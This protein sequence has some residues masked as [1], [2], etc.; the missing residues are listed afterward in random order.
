[1]EKIVFKKLLKRNPIKNRIYVIFD[2]NTPIY[3]GMASRQSIQGRLLSH[4][5]NYFVRKK[6]SKLSNL[7]FST[8]VDY[9]EW[10]IG[11]CTLDDVRIIIGKKTCCLKCAEA[12]LYLFYTKIKRQNI[13]GN[14]RVPNR[15]SK[16]KGKK[17]G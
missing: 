6:T 13:D 7:M 14:A 10:K 17:N 3:I 5:L 8:E 4:A 1:M 12:D 16:Y 11:I 9:F 2:G 15:C